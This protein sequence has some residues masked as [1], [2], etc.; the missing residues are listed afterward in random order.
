MRL[1]DD[2]KGHYLCDTHLACLPGQPLFIPSPR[3]AI[4]SSTPILSA[5]CVLD[6]SLDEDGEA[7]VI[8]L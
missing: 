4:A 5:S 7:R 1:L 8:V 3:N 6:F 2:M